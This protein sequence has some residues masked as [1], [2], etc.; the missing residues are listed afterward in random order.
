[1]NLTEAAYELGL[2]PSTVR[3]RIL[4]AELE[5]ERD[6]GRWVI[7]REEIERYR[8]SRKYRPQNARCHD[9]K[10]GNVAVAELTEQEKLTLEECGIRY[11]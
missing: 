9:G 10:A 5:A 3:A 4:A 6:G 2:A 1:M 8:R 11:Q 7:Y